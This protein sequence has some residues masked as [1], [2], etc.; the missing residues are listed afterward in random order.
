MAEV[1]T[2]RV[3]RDLH[4][5]LRSGRTRHFPLDGAFKETTHCVCPSSAMAHLSDAAWQHLLGRYGSRAYDLAAYVTENPEL[6]RP[7][8]AGEPDLHVEFVYQRRQEMALYDE[9]F[10]LRRTRLGLFHP[11]LLR[12]DMP[13]SSNTPVS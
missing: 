9:D 2:D 13:A 7:V 3:M 4:L 8:I 1:V 5:P 11:E 6:A 12:G 10:L